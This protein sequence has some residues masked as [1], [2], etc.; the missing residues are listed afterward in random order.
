[1]SEGRKFQ[2]FSVRRSDL[3]FYDCQEEGV[4]RLEVSGGRSVL[5]CSVQEKGVTRLVVSLGR[6]YQTFIVRRQE[7][8]DLYCQEEGVTSANIGDSEQ[9]W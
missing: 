3:V 7:L 4:T 8:P 1:M 9:L 5:T 6:S 2:T